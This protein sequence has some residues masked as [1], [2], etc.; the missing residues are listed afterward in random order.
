MRLGLPFVLLSAALLCAASGQAQW[1][2]AYERAERALAEEDWS[3]AVRQ[4]NVALEGQPESAAN[5]RTYGMRFISYFPYFK[6]GLAYYHLGQPE[7]ALEAFDTERRQGEIDRSAS[8]LQVLES[9]RQRIGQERTDEQAQRQSRA[10]SLIDEGLTTARIAADEE[11]YEDALAAVDRALAIAPDDAGAQGLRKRLLA[12]LA[13]LERSRAEQ[14]RFEVLI[15]KARR[16]LAEGRAGQAASSLSEAMAIR[17]ADP[18]ARLLRERAQQTLREAAV[19]RDDS[20]P[21]E[22]ITASLRRAELLATE[23]NLEAALDELQAA[24]ALDSRHVRARALQRRWLA[25]QANAVVANNRDRSIAALLSETDEHLGRGDYA[26]ALRTANR[27]LA[28]DPGNEQALRQVSRG[29]SRLSDV[30]LEDDGTPPVLLLDDEPGEGSWRVR[31]R[32]FTL[33]GTVYDAA[34]V[35]VRVA[36]SP[37]RST[38]EASADISGATA[39]AT[40]VRELQGVWITTFQWTAD[41]APGRSDY[42]VIAVDRSGNQVSVPFSVEYTVPFE[43]SIWFPILILLGFGLAFGAFGLVRRRRTQRLLRSRFNPYTAGAPILEQNRFFG[44]QL[45]LDYVLRRISNNS[46]MLYG[47]R[48]IG[49]TSFQHRLKRC[50]SE[51]NDPVHEF[52]PVFVD[53]QGTPQERFFATLAADLFHELSSKLDGIEPHRPPSGRDYGYRDLVRDLQS[54]LAKLADKTPKKVK[55]VLLIDEVDELNHYDPR[56][57]QR[58]RSLFMRAFAENLVAVVSGVSIKKQWERE[59]SPWYNFFQEIEVKPLD[60]TEAHALI[61]A[62][63]RGVFSFDHGVSAHIVERTHAKPYLIQRLCTSLVDRMHEES[64]RRVTLEDVEA[65]ARVEGL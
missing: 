31:E 10:Q 64:R 9:Y 23:G 45:L 24:L 35:E 40:E 33:T 57:N 60:P 52:Y 63:V 56:V 18:T 3:E 49:K 25:E 27:V 2:Q 6:L 20:D 39:V 65:A 58:L 8:D 54:V 48:R 5:Q 11:R 55:L 61:E 15:A 4:L 50:L 13:D 36:S 28:L 22:A 21:G 19:R 62:P 14:Q 17:P 37:G 1:Y 12:T 41:L 46:V 7:A 42:E 43:R 53:L 51:L 47:E 29:Y 38:A 34:P 26:R 30:L 59:G 16:D 44:R 32:G